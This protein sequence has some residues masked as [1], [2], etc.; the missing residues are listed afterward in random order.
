MS[1]LGKQRDRPGSQEPRLLDKNDLGCLLEFA[2][3]GVISAGALALIGRFYLGLLVGTIVF[4]GLL[5]LF[6]TANYV[7]RYF[8]RRTHRGKGKSKEANDHID[9]TPG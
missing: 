5:G 2:F 6:V 9:R 1:N 4:L 8:W 3:G 7:D